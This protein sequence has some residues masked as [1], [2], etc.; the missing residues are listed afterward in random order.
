VTR[1]DQVLGTSVPFDAVTTQALAYRAQFARNGAADG[2]I[3]AAEFSHG[4]VPEVAPLERMPE[5]GRDLLIVHYTGYVPGMRP[6]LELP[7][8]KLLVYHNITPARYFWNLEPYVAT[9]CQLGRDQL[10]RWVESADLSAGVSRFNADELELAGADEAVVVPILVDPKRLEGDAPC[11]DLPASRPLVM[12]VGRLSPHKRHD[13]V[14]RA[15]ALYQRRHAPDAALLCVGWALDKHYLERIRRIAEQE[16]AR[17]VTFL[18]EIPQEQLN[19]AYRS[20]DALLSLSEH[21]GFCIPLLEAFSFD[22]PVVARRA[23]GMAEVGGDAVLWLDE[24]DDVSVVAEALRLA[25]EDG[26]LRGELARRGRERLAEYAP[27]RV[28]AALGAAV[29]RALA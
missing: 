27:A 19:R 9:I 14:L 17:N 26:A 7:G 28:E 18:E 4:G 6:L 13:L 11:P 3:Y 29:E 24:D 1:I 12:C 15:F 22:L 2:G 21:E 20:A 23:G 5:D 10:R 8:R 16:G 25:V